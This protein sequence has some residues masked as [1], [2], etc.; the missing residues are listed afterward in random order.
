MLRMY[1]VTAIVDFIIYVPRAF[2]I[3]SIYSVLKFTI[4]RKFE[5]KPFIMLC[6]FILF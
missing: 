6:E 5:F 1:L 4:K 2:I 3:F